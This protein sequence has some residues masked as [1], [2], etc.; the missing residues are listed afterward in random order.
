MPRVG[1]IYEQ[2]FPDVAPATTI[3]ST[4]YNGFTHDVETD[5]NA[6]RPIVAG[7]TGA[8]SAEQA[9]FNLQAEAAA[10][11]VT[12]YD[13]HMWL[14]GS[15]RS[16]AGAT[17]A[18]NADNVF[19]GVVYIN[20]PLAYP[21]T[22]ANVVAEARDL[23]TGILYVRRKTAG[24]WGAW[25]QQ[26]GSSADTDARYVNVTGDTMTGPLVLP[27]DAANPLEAV[28]KQQLDA[29]AT[30]LDAAKVAKAG[31]TMTGDLI[32]T[33]ATPQIVLNKTAGAN[34]LVGQTGGVA[35]WIMQMGN[36]DLEGSSNNGSNFV[37]SSFNDGGGLI[38]HP[39]TV[40]RA[41]GALAA[42]GSI[43]SLY[44][45]VGRAGRGG[46]TNA[47][48]TFGIYWDNV[49]AQ[50]WINTTN[51]GNISLVSDPKI[52]KD[53]RAAPAATDEV[54]AWETIVFRYQDVGV[55]KDDGRDHYSFNAE[56]LLTVSPPCVR[57]TPSSKTA[58]DPDFQ[59]LTLDPIA[60]ISRL[61][62]CVQ[63]LMTRV[64]ALEGAAPP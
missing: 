37:L 32:V 51:V 58:A 64:E 4:V 12:N 16:A 53:M 21:P 10:Q 26:A 47:N 5:L 1:D 7:G 48:S 13:S 43:D 38:G 31:D 2:P 19:A 46:A 49:S 59:P 11:V 20:E 18:P 30:A 34:H 23:T 40:N 61:T 56:T 17:G 54:K 63:E 55:W 50:L 36:S 27:G 14:P 45:F 6:A 62:K 44:G 15:F 60:L 57:G 24:V 22:N 3:E 8:T 52:K 25:E 41:S 9:R 39:I 28:P 33:K 29:T 42:Y 35:R